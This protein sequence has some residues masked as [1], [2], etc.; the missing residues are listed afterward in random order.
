MMPLNDI[1]KTLIGI[2]ILLVMVSIL[3]VLAGK[4]S[5]LGKLPGDLIIQTENISCFVPIVSSI[6]LSLLLTIIL[7]VLLRMINK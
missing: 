2:G 3:V 6:I 7:N 5:F 4:F 1:G